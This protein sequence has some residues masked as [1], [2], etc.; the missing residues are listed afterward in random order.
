MVHRKHELAIVLLGIGK[1][2]A[3]QIEL[4]VFDERFP[5]GQS[6]RLE[7]RIRHAAADQRGVGN[8]HEVFNHFDFVADFCA[9]KNRDKRPRGI[10]QGFAQIVKLFFHQQAGGRLLDEARDADDRGVRAV[11]RAESVANENAIAKSSELLRESL[12]VFLFFRVEA[13]VFEQQDVAVGKRF[14]LGFGDGADAI[15]SEAHGSADERF[16]LFRDRQ[17]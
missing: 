9:A 3:R 7:K 10:R 17:K 8:L 4:V 11:C 14:A 5:Y 6:L 2:F 13:N 12:V 1:K 15:G 16:Q